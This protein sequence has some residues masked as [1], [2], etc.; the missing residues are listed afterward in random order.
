MYRFKVLTSCL[1]QLKNLARNQTVTRHVSKV[2]SA[3]FRDSRKLASSNTRPAA[4]L[5]TAM[6]PVDNSPAG[7]MG[8]FELICSLKSNDIIPV[9]KY[10]SSN[11]GLT[12][13]IAEVDGPVVGGYLALGKLH[14]YNPQEVFVLSV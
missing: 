1:G 13:V 8:G 2:P 10:K 7:N 4:A 14:D 3:Y 9:H 11:T 6:A 5:K 12:V